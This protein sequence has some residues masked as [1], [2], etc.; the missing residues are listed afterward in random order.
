MTNLL[1][2]KR[3]SLINALKAVVASAIAYLVGHLLGEWL[4]ISQMYAWIVITVLV[5][6]SSQPNLGG[7]LEKAKMRFLGTLIGSLCAIIIILVFPQM[8]I[9]QFI[10]GLAIIAI[11]VFTATNSTKYTY[12]GV[13]GSVTVAIILFSSDVSLATACYRT[14]EVLIGITIAIMVNRYFFPIHA[15]KRINQSFCD[16]VNCIAS[17]NNRLFAGGDYD[18]VLVEIF[19][20]FSK[21]IA[22]QKEIIHEKPNMDLKVLKAITRH[23]R[24]L[25]RYTSVVYDYIET[26]PEKR[27]KFQQN[28]A[29]KALYDEINHA[30]NVMSV[31]FKKSVFNQ[32]EYQQIIT[33]LEGLLEAFS[34]SMSIQ[35]ELRHASVVMFSFKKLIDTVQMIEENQNVLSEKRY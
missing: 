2:S 32:D 1:Y 33:K 12:T 31:S 35:N 4:N 30:F 26:Y 18:D 17:L 13:L 34:Q 15:Y 20:H 9:T 14:L 22:L 7:A 29:F 10:L 16:T 28:P 19:S 6:M 24:Q 21:Q 25:Y 3:Y 27:E 5:V 23:L 11:G 8:W